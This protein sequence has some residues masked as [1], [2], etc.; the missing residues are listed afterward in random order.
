MTTSREKRSIIDSNVPWR[1]LARNVLVRSLCGAFQLNFERTREADPATGVQHAVF[2]EP[3]N[4]RDHHGRPLRP[5]PIPKSIG[6][7]KAQLTEQPFSARPPSG[8][9]SQF[10]PLVLRLSAGDAE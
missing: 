1:R 9:S 6:R 10:Y 3:T 7:I 4:C 5:R 2:A 8:P